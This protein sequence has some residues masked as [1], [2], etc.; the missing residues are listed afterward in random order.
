[1]SVNMILC[2]G[3]TKMQYF[4]GQNLYRIWTASYLTH[5]ADVVAVSA[6]VSRVLF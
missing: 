3:L 6:V 4:A 5:G 2:N 1:M